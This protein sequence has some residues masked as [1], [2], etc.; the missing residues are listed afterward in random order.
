MV[1]RRFRKPV[2]TIVVRFILAV[3]MVGAKWDWNVDRHKLL[4]RLE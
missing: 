1:G 2:I 3:V 4:E